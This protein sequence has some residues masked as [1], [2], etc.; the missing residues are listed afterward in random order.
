MLTR[1]YDAPRD[2]AARIGPQTVRTMLNAG[3]PALLVTLSFL[4]TTLSVS[5]LSDVLGTLQTL[6]C[7]AGTSCTIFTLLRRGVPYVVTD[8]QFKCRRM[9]YH[10]FTFSLN[11]HAWS[12]PRPAKPYCCGWVNLWI[13]ITSRT[14][15]PLARYAAEHWV[16]RTRLE[17]LV[18]PGY[19]QIIIRMQC[20]YQ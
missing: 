19:N 12:L 17:C 14:N 11:R 3:C 2:Q 10:L 1:P 4:F 18:P 8:R 9:T 5:I 16:D 15:F 20:G 13:R 7:T 6:A